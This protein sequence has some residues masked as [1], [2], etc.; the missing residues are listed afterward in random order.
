[1]KPHHFSAGAK[2]QHLPLTL[3]RKGKKNVTVSETGWRGTKYRGKLLGNFSRG[4]RCTGTPTA[5]PPT[6]AKGKIMEMNTVEK[7]YQISP[8]IEN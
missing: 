8:P 2:W 6:S 7:A 3:T 1:V 5:F 4:L